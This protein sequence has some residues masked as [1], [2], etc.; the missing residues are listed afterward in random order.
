[1]LT[2]L[3]DAERRA[4]EVHDALAGSADKER[5]A[6]MTALSGAIGDAVQL[7]DDDEAAL[8]L[9]CLARLL[10]ELEGADVADALVDVLNSE[11][12]E[13]RSEAGD[14]LQGLAFERFKEVALACERALERLDEDD[15]PALLELPYLLVEVPEAGVVKLLG[16]FLESRDGDVVAAAIEALAEIGDPAAARMLLPLQ[17]DGRSCTVDDEELEPGDVTVGALAIEALELLRP[18]SVDGEG[19][20]G[21]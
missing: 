3:F 8:R 19:G 20:A 18:P 15:A 5:D 2:S 1:M 7:D 9:V 11:H 16:K 21:A 12:P 6:V 10:G 13:A 14:Q 17:G 4:R